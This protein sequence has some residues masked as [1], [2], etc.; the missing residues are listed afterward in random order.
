MTAN[1]VIVR[2]LYFF[3]CRKCKKPR[4]TSLNSET[5]RTEMCRTCRYNQVPK[6]QMKMFETKEDED[7]N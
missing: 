4:R 3:T 7:G 5:A 6:N 1:E 2:K